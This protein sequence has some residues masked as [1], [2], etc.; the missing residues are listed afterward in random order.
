MSEKLVFISPSGS[1]YKI[2][3]KNKKKA[4]EAGFVLESEEDAKARIQQEKYGS[5]FG[6]EARAFGEGAARGLTFGL[7]D[8]AIKALGGDVEGLEA[9]QRLN[10]VASTVGNIAGSVGGLLVPGGALAGLGKLGVGVKSAAQLGKAAEAGVLATKIAQSTGALGRTGA[11]LVGGAVE[12]IPYALGNVLSEKVLRD[13]EMSAEQIMS[14]VG[15]DVV[16]GGGLSGALHGTGEALKLGRN[17]SGKA[18]EAT[19]VKA[20]KTYHDFWNKGVTPDQPATGF[21]SAKKEQELTKLSTSPQDIRNEL[22]KKFRNQIISS[23]DQGDEYIRSSYNIHKSDI[24]ASLDSV[25]ASSVK[26]SA[27][28]L[29]FSMLQKIDDMRESGVKY[30]QYYTDAFDKF[31]NG[32][33]KSKDDGLIAAISK[34]NSAYE[35]HTLIDTFKKNTDHLMGYDI[36]DISRL[37]RA[38]RESIRELRKIRGEI[39]SMLENEKIWGEA[40]AQQSRYNNKLSDYLVAKKTLLKKF[41]VKVPAKGGDKKVISN[42]KIN[43]YMNQITH[44]RSDDTTKLLENFYDAQIAFIVEMESRLSSHLSQQQL[45]SSLK[46]GRENFAFLHKKAKDFLGENAK[47]RASGY[48]PIVAEFQAMFPSAQPAFNVLQKSSQVVN[49]ADALKAIS[50]P[51]RMA[52]ASQREIEGAKSLLSLNAAVAGYSKGIDSSLRFLLQAPIKTSEYALKE[53]SKIRGPVSSGVM[54]ARGID[55]HQKKIDERITKANFKSKMDGL[56]AI[57]KNPDELLNKIEKSLH[58]ISGA[59]SVSQHIALKSVSVAQFLLD[60]A[61]KNP[62]QQCTDCFNVNGCL[63]MA[64]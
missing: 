53:V 35:V 9:R 34:A 38:E 11:A 23:S 63:V 57:A 26:K 49:Y 20:S 37:P 22:Q 40:G 33:K 10:P 54:S 60:K 50:T 52:S 2:P 43:T 58:G 48:F 21:F 3:A 5:D 42:V 14:H 45:G 51:K 28:D 64:K 31:L 1:K 39:V 16:L 56:A 4:L 59:D 6:S 62:T 17:I 7:S 19:K 47:I 32:S 13:P 55:S 61:P 36:S 29:A 24:K 27:D 25:D 18:Y 15:A 46:K 12:S 41:G 8:A 44:D 30:D